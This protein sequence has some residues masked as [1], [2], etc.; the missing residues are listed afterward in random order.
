MSCGHDHNNDYSGI[1]KD[2]ELIYGRKTGYGSYGP[3]DFL[4]GATVFSLK[5]KTNEDGSLDFDQE[6]YNLE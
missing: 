6:S 5:E 3:N 2:I 1:Y 4:N